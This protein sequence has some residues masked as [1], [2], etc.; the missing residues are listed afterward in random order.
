MSKLYVVASGFGSTAG[1]LNHIN[2]FGEINEA[3][4][5]SLAGATAVTH[6]KHGTVVEVELKIVYPKIRV[7]ADSGMVRWF[8]KGATEPFAAIAK[9]QLPLDADGV[10]ISDGAIRGL[11]DT[12][13]SVLIGVAI[14][15]CQVG[16][17][18]DDSIVWFGK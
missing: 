5:M 6:Q 15:R 3:M 1:Y 17:K 2:T 16:V 9:A 18:F 12:G 10:C 11:K 7:S 13:A 14:T 8:L 4:T